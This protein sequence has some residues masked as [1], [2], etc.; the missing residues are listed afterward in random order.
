MKSVQSEVFDTPPVKVA[1]SIS[2]LT[3]LNAREQQE[4]KGGDNIH[5]GIKK[6]MIFFPEFT[7]SRHLFPSQTDRQTEEFVVSHRQRFV[8]LHR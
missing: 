5:I 7:D 4:E 3:H 1:D 8:V 6:K 2:L